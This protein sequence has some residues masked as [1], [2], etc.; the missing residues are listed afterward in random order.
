M[1]VF[2]Q[3]FWQIQNDRLF[4][5]LD[6]PLCQPHLFFFFLPQKKKR[7]QRNKLLSLNFAIPVLYFLHL[8]F[9]KYFN[10]KRI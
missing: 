10:I 2:M 5:L 3:K 7:A 8:N 1:R 4:N 6:K 9:E